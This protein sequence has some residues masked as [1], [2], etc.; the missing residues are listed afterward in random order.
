MYIKI[1]V[2]SVLA[3]SLLAFSSCG[4]SS[5]GGSSSGDG[6]A[7]V[8]AAIG[9]VFSSSSSSGLLEKRSLP[10][11][12]AELFIKRAIAQSEGEFPTT[13]E[14]VGDD[15]GAEGVTTSSSI[16]AGTYGASS[17]PVTV[18]A[19]QDCESAP[20]DTESYASFVVSSHDLS[21]TD[22]D[23]NT[24]SL[25]MSDAS[26]IWRQMDETTGT[27]IYGTFSV[28]AGGETFTGIQC[29]LT[30]TGGDETGGGTFDGDC[31]DSDGN[32]VTQDSEM[33]CTDA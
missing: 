14:S 31:E 27:A 15:N 16:T 4:S 10:S 29:S 5:S 24:A 22:G 20:D 3:A 7:S 11:R 2:L 9:A 28:T 32:A 8:G 18:T 17:N 13:C 30:I 12:I 26:G 23:G 21:C 1:S 25:T 19:D 33:T 6:S